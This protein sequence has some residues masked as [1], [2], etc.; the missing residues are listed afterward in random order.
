MKTLT[1]ESA[2]LW[3]YAQNKLV[4]G[5]SIRVRANGKFSS[6]SEYSDSRE[7][8]VEYAIDETKRCGWEIDAADIIWDEDGD[9]LLMAGDFKYADDVTPSLLYGDEDTDSDDIPFP[10]FDEKT[11]FEE[12][13]EVAKEFGDLVATAAYLKGHRVKKS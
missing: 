5:F 1:I 9:G 6:H 7:K 3:S 12:G 13:L 8:A 10:A 11:A 2:E 4:N